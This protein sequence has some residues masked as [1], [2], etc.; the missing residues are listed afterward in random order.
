MVNFPPKR[1]EKLPENYFSQRNTSIEAVANRPLGYHQHTKAKRNLLAVQHCSIRHQPPTDK[2]LSVSI[3]QP[4]R[5]DA[6]MDSLSPQRIPHK[7]MTVL[8]VARGHCS[9]RL[10]SSFASWLLEKTFFTLLC[11]HYSHIAYEVLHCQND[12]RCWR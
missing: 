10:Q 12:F 9:N 8:Q 11:K 4:R 3:L 5:G 7:P 1:N 6:N 2:A